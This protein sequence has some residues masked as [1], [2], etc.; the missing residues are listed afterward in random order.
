MTT[1]IMRHGND[2]GRLLG[3]LH[4]TDF[5]K[6][7]QCA[8]CHKHRSSDLVNC[9]ISLVLR[10]GVS[11]V[12]GLAGPHEPQRYIIEQL[13]TFKAHYRALIQESKGR[14]T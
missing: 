12:G 9:R 13:K 6:S 10:I 8:S 3:L 11:R 4:G 14:A 2:N 7:M 1:L 5:T